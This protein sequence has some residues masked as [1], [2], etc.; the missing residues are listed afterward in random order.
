MMSDKMEARVEVVRSVINIAIDTALKTHCPLVKIPTTTAID[1]DDLLGE[2]DTVEY[3]LE[4]LKAHGWKDSTK[5]NLTIKDLITL[6]EGFN[7]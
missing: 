6:T 4:V 3:A 1:I 5:Q 2:Q 7:K